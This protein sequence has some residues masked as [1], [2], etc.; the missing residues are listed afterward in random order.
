MVKDK[1]GH[2]PAFPCEL[3]VP[4]KEYRLDFHPGMSKRYW[5]AVMIAQGLMSCSAITLS[6]PDIIEK[7]YVIADDLIKQENE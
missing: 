2:D 5:T 1:E 3:E 4:G 6:Y 7:A